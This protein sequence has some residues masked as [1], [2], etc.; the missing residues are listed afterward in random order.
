ANQISDFS[1]T[2]DLCMC[3]KK[4]SDGR[5][6]S[7]ESGVWNLNKLV[8]IA[9]KK[10]CDPVTG[11]QENYITQGHSLKNLSSE[12]MMAELVKIAQKNGFIMGTVYYRT[13]CF[14]FGNYIIGFFLRLCFR[15]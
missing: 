14:Y 7:L 10:K 9:Q 12:I 4:I 2:F 15:K 13:Y 5:I 1:S 6:W 3:A 11:D 8:K